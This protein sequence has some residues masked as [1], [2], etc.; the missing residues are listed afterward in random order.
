VADPRV[1]LTDPAPLAV[2]AGTR[3]R[4]RAATFAWAAAIA[5]VALEG[6]HEV[7]GLGGPDDLYENW[8]HSTILIGATVLCALRATS[9]R[10]SRGAW[11]AITVGMACWSAGTVLWTL[12]YY[13]NPDPPYPTVADVL[14]LLW[15]P[16]VAVGVAALV[17]TRVPVF[18]LHR[19]LDG[20][21]VTLL[22]LVATFPLTL[23]PVQQYFGH[24]QPA[25]LVDVSYPILDTLMVGGILGSLALLAWRPDRLLLLL[26]AGFL[27]CALADVAYAVR[28]A[29]GVATSGSYDFLWAAGALLIGYAATLRA[30]HAAATAQPV[31]WRAI[32]LPLSASLIA[33]ALQVCI[34]LFPS[35]DTDTHR[36]VVLAVLLIAVVQIVL[37]RPRGGD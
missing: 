28:Q 17:R 37:A 26:G 16:W 9:D 22:A 6:A 2:G 18:E 35:F 27:A 5:L 30:P 25:A 3:P 29:R 14:W 12:L 11:L 33:V 1:E 13:G 21:A 15:Y 23:Q 32:A 10:R 31:G 20:F 7:L 19:W 4:S 36:V 8:I 34:I 24:S